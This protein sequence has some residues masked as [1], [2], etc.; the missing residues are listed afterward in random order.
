[1]YKIIY[2]NPGINDVDI[3]YIYNVY[4]DTLKDVGA[5]IITV[6]FEDIA[7]EFILR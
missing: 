1:M 5:F 3:P 4:P 2:V 7:M 6:L